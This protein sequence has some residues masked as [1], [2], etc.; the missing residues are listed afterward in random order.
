M[1]SWESGRNALP[2]RVLFNLNTTDMSK[3]EPKSPSKVVIIPR[4]PVSDK[5]NDKRKSG[6]EEAATDTSSFRNRIRRFPL[7]KTGVAVIVGRSR[8]QP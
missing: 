7:R 3:F 5:D 1:L 4:P 6:E 2:A 8:C